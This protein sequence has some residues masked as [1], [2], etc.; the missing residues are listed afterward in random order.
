VPCYIMKL[1]GGVWQDCQCHCV[2]VL[3]CVVCGMWDACT[4]PHT[5]FGRGTYND[6]LSILYIHSVF[7]HY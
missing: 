7:I 5:K 2:C 1:K 6:F 4:N 3:L